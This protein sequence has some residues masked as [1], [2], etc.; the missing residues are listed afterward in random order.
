MFE[1][2]IGALSCGDHLTCRIDF[3][4]KVKCLRFMLGLVDLGAK[5]LLLHFTVVK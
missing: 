2:R 4:K 3:E 1:T 5:M